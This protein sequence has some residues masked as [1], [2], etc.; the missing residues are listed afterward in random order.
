[1]IADHYDVMISHSYH[2]RRIAHRL[3][4]R[5]LNYGLQIWCRPSTDHAFDPLTTNVID[6]SNYVVLCISEAYAQ[7]YR[8]QKE[9]RYASDNRKRILMVNIS[10]NHVL[11]DWLSFITPGQ[12][13]YQLWNE[14][15]SCHFVCE[16]LIRT[17]SKRPLSTERDG[18]S[19]LPLT[20]SLSQS[21][22]FYRRLIQRTWR[23]NTGHLKGV[24]AWKTI[25]GSIGSKVRTD[26]E[27][28][29]RHRLDTD[30]R[31]MRQRRQQLSNYFKATSTDHFCAFARQMR[32]N[33][34][35]WENFCNK[36]KSGYM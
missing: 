6:Q 13:Q 30:L 16:H 4:S 35:E 19:S 9:A 29:R 2:D 17:I 14:K 10:T 5:L 7:S 32:Q 25:D 33:Q 36:M 24:P 31:L 15:S 11:R 28:K 21:D 26:A 34:I 12:I 18:C 8:C 20:S 1:M 22:L 23:L 27:M 3:A